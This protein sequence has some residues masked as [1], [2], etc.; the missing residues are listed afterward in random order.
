M[1]ES[2][3]FEKIAFKKFDNNSTYYKQFEVNNCE[4]SP[5]AWLLKRALFLAAFVLILVKL[6]VSLT[7]DLQIELTSL[8]IRLFVAHQASCI[9]C[10]DRS[11]VP[12]Q[13]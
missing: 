12:F 2:Y 10:S 11:F 3:K 1:F 9:G 4:F 7:K 13:L 8:L 6:E 5:I